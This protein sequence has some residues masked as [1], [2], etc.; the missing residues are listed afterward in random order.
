M[1]ETLIDL[2]AYL[3]SRMIRKEAFPPAGSPVVQFYRK[4]EN[5]FRFF[6]KQCRICHRPP[7]VLYYDSPRFGFLCDDCHARAMEERMASIRAVRNRCPP[8]KPAAPPSKHPLWGV[9]LF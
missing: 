7:N 1:K 2:S 9:A 4:R 5:L 8:P 3:A 6:R